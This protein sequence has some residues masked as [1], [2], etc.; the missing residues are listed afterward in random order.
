MKKNINIKKENTNLLNNADF[1]D[2]LNFEAEYANEVKGGHFPNYYGEEK[3]KR[4]VNDVNLLSPNEQ[5]D[6][7]Y[8]LFIGKN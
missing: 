2:L 7:V 1:R 8:N 5:S 3:Q 4:L 6:L